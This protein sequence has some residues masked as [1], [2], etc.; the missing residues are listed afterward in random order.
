MKWDK[1]NTPIMSRILPGTMIR[2]LPP[3]QK[4]GQK[5]ANPL[6]PGGPALRVVESAPVKASA[7]TPSPEGD[8]V[9]QERKP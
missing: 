6:R 2:M 1:G 4:T 9:V 7:E 5:R 3:W 8:A